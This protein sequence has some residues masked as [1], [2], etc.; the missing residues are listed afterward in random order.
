MN[1]RRVV[2]ALVIATAGVGLQPAWAQ[3]V[4]TDPTTT[5]RNTVTAVLKDRL[6]QTLTLQQ[7]RLRR[8]AARLSAL[9]SLAKYAV[10]EVP[11]W[12]THDWAGFL[13]ANGYTA[14][15]NY[16]D[17]T[18]AEFARVARARQAAEAS[19]LAAMSPNARDVVTRA[20]ATLDLADSSIMVGT[21]QTGALRLNG[22]RELAAI[23]ALERHVIDPSDAQSTTAVLDKISGAVLVET[24]QKQTRLQL[25]AAVA[26]QLLVE[27]K[28]SRDTETGVMNMQ[29]GRLRDGRA[30]NTSLLSGASADLRGWRQP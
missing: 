10:D 19:I 24:R 26:E 2:I 12:R 20:L 6:L 3:W 8:M 28:R 18:G 16:G 17:S 29:L 30:A 25:L 4:V 23:D 27:N 11:R 22:R 5:A 1:S 9:T 21:H 7:E 14:A 13:Y 15:L